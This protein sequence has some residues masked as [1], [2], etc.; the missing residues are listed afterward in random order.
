[1]EKSEGAETGTTKNKVIDYPNIGKATDKIPFS[2][3]KHHEE[4]VRVWRLCVFDG[5][6][7]LLQTMYLPVSPRE[8]AD[9]Q[10][11]VMW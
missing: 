10:L 6:K 7:C 3:M 4:L 2:Q 1:M 9:R 11:S 8:P 5:S